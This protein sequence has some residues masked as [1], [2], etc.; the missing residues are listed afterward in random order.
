MKKIKVDFNW[1][2]Y[3]VLEH[4]HKYLQSK[5]KDVVFDCKSGDDS[6]YNCYVTSKITDDKFK[7]IESTALEYVNNFDKDNVDHFLNITWMRDHAASGWRDREFFATHGKKFEFDVYDDG[8]WTIYDATKYGKII[9]QGKEVNGLEG[10][11]K[12][13]A[14][15]K[16]LSQLF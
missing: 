6:K 1:G 4:T 12:L 5:F 8:D 11:K 10:K 3:H 15:L 9:A 14:T 7:E 13:V 2:E 16:A